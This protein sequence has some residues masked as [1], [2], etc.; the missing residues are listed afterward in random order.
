MPPPLS[1]PS[2]V[3]GASKDI[4]TD[5]AGGKRVRLAAKGRLRVPRDKAGE[6]LLIIRRRANIDSAIHPSRDTPVLKKL[7]YAAVS[8]LALAA[9]HPIASAQAER[10][11]MQQWLNSQCQINPASPVCRRLI[12]RKQPVTRPGTFRPYPGPIDLCPP[13][14]FRLDP[15]D[16]CVAVIRHR[17]ER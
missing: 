4:D 16:G 12:V 10:E 15:R 2:L 14:Q 3:D 8:V 7:I 9:P 5:P 17:G 1:S 13:P 11:L 6:G